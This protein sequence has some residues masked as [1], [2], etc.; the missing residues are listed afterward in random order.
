MSPSRLTAAAD[1]RHLWWVFLAFGAF[2]TALY[3][4]VPPLKGSPLVIN[5]LGLYGLLAMVAGIRFYRPRARAAWWLF[6]LGVFL[7]WVGDVYTYSI[8]I[9]FNVTV[10]FPSFGDAVYLTMYPVLMVGI[11]L[12]VRRRTQRG[13]GPRAVNSLRMTLGQALVCGLSRIGAQEHASTSWRV[14]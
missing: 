2:V 8:R 7:F 13:G 4:L 11:M 14:P 3:V 9:V 1:R 12:L 5:G 10:P 6:V